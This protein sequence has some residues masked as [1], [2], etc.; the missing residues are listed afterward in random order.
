MCFM[1]FIQTHLPVAWRILH[2]SLWIVI[3]SGMATS[4]AADSAT[5]FILVLHG[6]A[7]VWRNELT[8]ER[9]RESRETMRAALTVGHGVLRTNGTSLDAVEAA[10]RVLED[11]PVFNAGKGSVLT[12]EGTVEMD[13]SIM[14]GA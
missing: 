11:S 1:N 9:E 8:P 10:L 12:S 7:G 14:D 2:A 5:N 6:G 3:V 13:A 4:R